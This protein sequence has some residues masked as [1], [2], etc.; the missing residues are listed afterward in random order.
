M[1]ARFM[2]TPI[3]WYRANAAWVGHVKSGEYQS[4]YEQNYGGR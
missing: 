3:E 2:V 4:Y 1:L